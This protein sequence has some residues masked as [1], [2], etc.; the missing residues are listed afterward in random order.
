MKKDIKSLTGLLLGAVVGYFI[1]REIFAGEEN[2][3][4]V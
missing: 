4:R 1:A 2:S 3:V